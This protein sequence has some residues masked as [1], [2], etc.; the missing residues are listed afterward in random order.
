MHSKSFGK[1][2]IYRHSESRKK[3]IQRINLRHDKL[4]LL[5]KKMS[6][7][8]DLIQSTYFED[9]DHRSV[10]LKAVYDGLKFLN[11]S[12]INLNPK[13]LMQT[14]KF[15]NL[16][17]KVGFILSNLTSK[18]IRQTIIVILSLFFK[19]SAQEVKAPNIL[20]AISDDQSFAHTSFAGAPFINTPTFDRLAK[21]GVF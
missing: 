10:V 8:Q 9:E 15:L 2:N 6:R 17:D 13:S 14:F 1:T 5:I 3:N 7:G 19:V 11:A 18:R 16:L 21:E 4:V 20:F 12:E